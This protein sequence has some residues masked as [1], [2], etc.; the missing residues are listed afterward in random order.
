MQY[1]VCFWTKLSKKDRKKLCK[2]YLTNGV[3]PFCTGSLLS[4]IYVYIVRLTSI[5][6]SKKI[7]KNPVFKSKI[8][9]LDV[10]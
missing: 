3:I 10:C 9:V 1:L 5:N 2:L 4:Y 8:V 7:L 6:L